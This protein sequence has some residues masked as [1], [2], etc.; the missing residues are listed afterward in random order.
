MKIKL[1]VKKYIERLSHTWSVLVG[2]ADAWPLPT[3]FPK[4]SDREVLKE[5]AEY[6]DS[7]REMFWVTDKTKA[8]K[9]ERYKVALLVAYN[10]FPYIVSPLQL[11]RIK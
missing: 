5:L 4:V 11:K 2:R 3:E 8:L 10:N 7:M 6:H 9:H 1:N